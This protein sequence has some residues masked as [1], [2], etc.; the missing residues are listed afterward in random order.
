MLHLSY[1]QEALNPTPMDLTKYRNYTE[2]LGGKHGEN[3]A[4]LA[5]YHKTGNFADLQ[6]IAKGMGFSQQNLQDFHNYTQNNKQ[7]AQGLLTQDLDGRKEY[8]AQHPE[9][10]GSLMSPGANFFDSSMLPTLGL[11]ALGLGLVGG[12]AYL[13]NKYKNR[14]KGLN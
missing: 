3:E 11:G 10:S 9:N 2:I 7:D 8:M 1:L 5:N 12:G 13:Y 14:Q 6:N 4:A